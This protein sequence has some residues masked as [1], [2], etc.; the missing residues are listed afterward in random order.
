LHVG[1]WQ[2][3]DSESVSFGE[4]LDRMTEPAGNIMMTFN[5]RLL[6]EIEVTAFGL[7]FIKY[8]D[9]NGYPLFNE[10]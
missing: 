10:Q 3:G 1:L 2:T 5:V 7:A 9:V 4:Y 8:M 6:S